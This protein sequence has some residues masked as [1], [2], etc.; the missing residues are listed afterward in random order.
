MAGLFA[1]SCPPGLRLQQSPPA[2]RRQPPL[3]PLINQRSGPAANGL[4]RPLQLVQGAGYAWAR[5]HLRQRK[6]RNRTSKRTTRRYQ[7]CPLV[8]RRPTRMNVSEIGRRLTAKGTSRR[9]GAHRTTQHS[10]SRLCTR[11]EHLMRRPH[12]RRSR[13]FGRNSGPPKPAAPW[14][15]N[16][17]H[18]TGK[19]SAPGGRRRS[20]LARLPRPKVADTRRVGRAPRRASTSRSGALRAQRK[21]RAQRRPNA[22]CAFAPA[23]PRSQE[24]AHAACRAPRRARG[25]P[26]I[27]LNT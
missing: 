22:S 17:S 8:L 14:K 13:P 5:N 24:A 20:V 2:R 21:R 10:C 3:G 6:M 11:R 7:R 25:K 26:D 15:C 23:P 16:A 27:M 1:T 4:P 9:R 19:S 18:P 12:P